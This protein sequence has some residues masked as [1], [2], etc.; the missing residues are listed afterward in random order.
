MQPRPIALRSFKAPGIP[1][2]T[3]YGYSLLPLLLM[4]QHP[5]AI[6]HPCGCRWRLCF[7]G[8]CLNSN[9]PLLR[10]PWPHPVT[11]HCAQVPTWSFMAPCLFTDSSWEVPALSSL[12]ML[13]PASALPASLKPSPF[14]NWGLQMKL[15][16]LH[17]SHKMGGPRVPS[18]TFLLTNHSVPVIPRCCF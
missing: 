3:F 7:T 13:T 5:S 11:G 6:S 18:L 9:W 2:G 10:C 16:F 12:L 1:P 14:F 17:I 4:R 8:G 15:D